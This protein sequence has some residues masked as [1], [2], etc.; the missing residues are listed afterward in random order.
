MSGLITC[1]QLEVELLSEFLHDC[2]KKLTNITFQCGQIIP[3]YILH[4]IFICIFFQSIMS[5]GAL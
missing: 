2:V 5:A 1:L 3:S 4:G